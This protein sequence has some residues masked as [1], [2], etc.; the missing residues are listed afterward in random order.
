[1]YILYTSHLYCS[2]NIQVQSLNSLN[3]QPPGS[4]SL[5]E[6]TKDTR[7]FVTFFFSLSG[8]ERKWASSLRN[9]FRTTDFL[10]RFFQ[11]RATKSQ[12]ALVPSDDQLTDK[13]S[14]TSYT[15]S[16]NSFYTFERPP[17]L[18]FFFIALAQIRA[19]GQCRNR[20]SQLLLHLDLLITEGSPN[21][22]EMQDRMCKWPLGA[23]N[24]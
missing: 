21:L 18:P 14:L 16:C 22:K 7:D 24:V 2:Y 12:V 23:K 6:S 20:N 19:K 1:M 3:S 11:R 15:T 9:V 8:I 4:S 17:P 10:T 5:P 13:K